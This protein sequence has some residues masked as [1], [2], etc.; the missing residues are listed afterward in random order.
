MS[1]D[2]RSLFANADVAHTDL[3]EQVEAARFTDGVLMRVTSGVADLRVDPTGEGL[4]RQVLHG[5][6]VRVLDPKTGFARDETTGYVGY[7]D[8]AD[9]GPWTPATHRVAARSTLVFDAPDF[10]R[11][12]PMPLSC[13]AMISVSTC[14]ERYAQTDDGC[15]AIAAHIIE[16][17]RPQPDFAATAERLIGTPYLWGGNSAFGIDCS[18]LVQIALQ[19]AQIACP[20]DSDQQRAE[21]GEPLP[22]QT[23][24]QRND[25]MF[26]KGHV[27]L[28][29]DADTLLHANAHHMA[30]AWEPIAQAMAR[31]DHQGDG[32]LLA[33]KRL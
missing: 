22:P 8:P 4:D 17:D 12:N 29:F 15:Y 16:I 33:H 9:L 3:R 10:K 30:V 31:I 28:V 18:G 14:A 27:A 11:A 25:L 24:P 7:I 6:P 21:L 32:P 20:G 5:H 26:W 13:G 23:T 19:A 1:I 2:R